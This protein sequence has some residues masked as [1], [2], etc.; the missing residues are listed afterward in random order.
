MPFTWYFF[1]VDADGSLLNRLKNAVALTAVRR[2]ER[3]PMYG[4]REVTAALHE[5]ANSNFELPWREF[6]RQQMPALR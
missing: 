5:T 2:D 1:L 4:A 3:A 6:N